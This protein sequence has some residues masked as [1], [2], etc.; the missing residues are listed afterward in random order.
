MRTLGTGTKAYLLG[1]ALL[2]TSPA[3]VTTAAAQPTHGRAAGATSHAHTAGA[4][5]AATHHVGSRQAPYAHTHSHAIAAHA[6][7][8]G[9]A[10]RR[11]AVYYSGISCV[12]YARQVSGIMVTG[13]AWQWWGNAVGQYARGY[14]PEIGS[15]LNFRSNSRMPLGHVAVVTRVVNER[16]IIVD[17]ANWG[18]SGMRGR[19]SRDVAIVDVS[20]ANNWSA[21]RVE[22]GRRGEFGA[23]YPT[24]GF[25][26]NRPD[27]G[28]V[29]AS[30]SQPAP[31]PEINPVPSDLRPAAERPWH[32][33]EEVAESPNRAPRRI[34]LRVTRVAS[35][36]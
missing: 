8:H 34:D 20:E 23:V 19:V 28:L 10:S 29:T 4:R 5:I 24:Y 6:Y 31:L 14:R 22:I 9:H 17:Q 15:V 33:Y 12:P 3:C 25:I 7:G 30:A 21:V 36:R 13:N 32:T 27:T 11:T 26:Y 2:F 35:D 18:S 16:E 1:S